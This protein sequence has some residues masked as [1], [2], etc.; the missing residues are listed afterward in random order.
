[1][2][3]LLTG[4]VLTL[5]LTGLV[6]AGDP[7]AGEEIA[8]KECVS[9]H[10]EKGV[11]PTQA[12]YARLAGLGEGYLFKQLKDIKSGDREVAEMTGIV[13]DLDEQDLRDLAAYYN[14]REMPRGE[15]SADKVD[16]GE[17]LYRGG[18]MSRD[19]AACIACHG[20]NGLGNEPAGYPR[21]SGQSAEY[22]VNAL[23]DYRSGDR[24]YDDQSQIMGD[25]AS[26]L[27]DDEIEAVAE[28]IE[29]LY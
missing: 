18:D 19:I 2:R 11:E 1:M 29:G 15:A 7:E 23:K 8:E 27:D 28:Y 13:S 17:D 3:K 14:E 24:V 6:E 9:C 21:V 26:E 16:Q 12:S 20:P 10:G 22:V 25:V 4:L 5:G